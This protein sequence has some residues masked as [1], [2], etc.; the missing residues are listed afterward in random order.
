MIENPVATYTLYSNK[1]TFTG[2]VGDV[3]L[4]EQYTNG[5]FVV[6]VDSFGDVEAL[7]VSDMSEPEA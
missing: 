2:T 3:H 1:D 7:S 4:T 6:D 5:S